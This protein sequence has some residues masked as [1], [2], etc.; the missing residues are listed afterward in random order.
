LFALVAPK[1][2]LLAGFVEPEAA[3]GN[4]LAGDSAVLPRRRRLREATVSGLLNAE[5][6]DHHTD[7]PD[8]FH[9][10]RRTRDETEQDD[11]GGQS[12][13]PFVVEFHEPSPCNGGYTRSPF[14]EYSRMYQESEEAAACT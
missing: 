5:I 11:E 1:A 10:A 8:Q 9:Q 2:Y 12:L 3:G 13:N 14:L 7:F 4:P 6:V